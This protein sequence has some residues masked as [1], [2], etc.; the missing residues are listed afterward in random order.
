[1]RI[2]FVSLAA[3]SSPGYGPWTISLAVY[4]Y[5]VAFE[6]NIRYWL[7]S[8]SRGVVPGLAKCAPVLAAVKQRALDGGCGPALAG[9]R[10]ER[11]GERIAGWLGRA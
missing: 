11:P 8:V 5:I 1:M 4:L 9:G 7:P 2:S 6:V 10:R 3:L